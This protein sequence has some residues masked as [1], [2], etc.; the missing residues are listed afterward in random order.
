V[1]PVKDHNLCHASMGLKN[2][3]GLLG[4]RRNQFHQDIHAIISDLSLMIRPTLSILDGS[5]VLMRNGPTGGDPS[6][7]KEADAVLAAT[8][9][10][11]A[12]AWAY[13][14]LLERGTDY[15][16]YLHRAEEKGGGVVDYRGRIEEVA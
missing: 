8:D 9:Q 3:Y 13:E 16:E 11:A 7:I 2:W 12:D 4:G 10:V 6:D 5:R 15:P 14:H 1:A